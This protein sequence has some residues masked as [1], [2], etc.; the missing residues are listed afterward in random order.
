MKKVKKRKI[1]W[2]RII[3]LLVLILLILIS[4]GIVLNKNKKENEGE[5]ITNKKDSDTKEVVEEVFKS[6]PKNNQEF[7]ELDDG[8]YKT[9]NGYT[10]EIKNGVA[11]IDDQIIVNKTFNVDKS[12]VP[13]NPYN[14]EV[15]GDKCNNCI[16]KDVMEAFNLMAADA[17]AI[18]LNIYIA[19]GYRSY[20][21]QEKLY[22][23]Y[24]SIS[25]TIGADTYSARA[26]YSEHQTGTCFDLNSVDDSFASTSEGKW[27]GENASL[28]GFIIRYPKNGEDKTGYKYESWHLR[29]VGMELASKLYKGNGEWITLEEYYGISSS[30][31]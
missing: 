4:L 15:T 16:N 10:L 24:V 30:Y 19:S 31:E 12:Y 21:Y 8:V 6:S 18:G 25:G 22:N 23:N 9:D 29:Y 26:G 13:V 3:I 28:Y 5:L 2:D 27:I 14:G 20:A 17:K 11:Y 1:K 7:L